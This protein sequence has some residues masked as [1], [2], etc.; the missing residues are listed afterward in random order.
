MKKNCDV[1]KKPFIDKTTNHSGKYCKRKKCITVQNRRQAQ[2]IRDN[3]RKKE[4]KEFNDGMTWV[5]VNKK[6]SRKWNAIK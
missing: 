1:C 4:R 5:E 6:L 3:R 2:R